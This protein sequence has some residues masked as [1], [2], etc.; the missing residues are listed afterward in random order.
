[1]LI[2]EQARIRE[3][4][5]MIRHELKTLEQGPLVGGLVLAWV[6][7]AGGYG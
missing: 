4:G 1:M 5:H 7:R 3:P 2:E 6:A